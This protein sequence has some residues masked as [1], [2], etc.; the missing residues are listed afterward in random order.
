MTLFDFLNIKI[1]QM[2]NQYP[3]SNDWKCVTKN[4]KLWGSST[5]PWWDYA[6]DLILITLGINSPQT[7]TTIL[8]EEINYGLCINVSK[9]ETM[10][11]NHMLL[12]FLKMN[13]LTLI[14]LRNVP[15]QNSTKFKYLDSYIFQN[16]LN[17]R[18]IEINHRTQMAYTKSQNLKVH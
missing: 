15:L 4:V 17:T 12:C 11:L 3:E 2:W 7:A 18:D 6:D 5:V 8:D 14:R 9:T 13:T 10:V 16:E 1:E